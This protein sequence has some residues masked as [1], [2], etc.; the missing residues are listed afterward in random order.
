MISIQQLSLP[1]ISLTLQEALKDGFGDAVMMC[2]MPE[3]CKFPS[4]DS[5]QERFLWTYKEA[6]LATHSIIDLLLKVG[7]TERLPHALGFASLDPFF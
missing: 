5:C 2:D 4:L 3:P 1:I 7:G 6:D